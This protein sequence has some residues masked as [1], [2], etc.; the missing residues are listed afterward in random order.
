MYDPVKAWNILKL[1]MLK[2]QAVSRTL[3]QTPECL[4]IKKFFLNKLRFFSQVILYPNT[5]TV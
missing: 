4:K 1:I 3:D 2:D 5:T